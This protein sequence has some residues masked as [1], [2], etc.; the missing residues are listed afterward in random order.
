MT[1]AGAITLW[2]IMSI[3]FGPTSPFGAVESYLPYPTQAD[4]GADIM[5]QR[6]KFEDMGLEVT[7][8]RC[9]QTTIESGEVE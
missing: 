9:I 6:R 2:T 1:S 5:A 4:C 3:T 8:V 7:M